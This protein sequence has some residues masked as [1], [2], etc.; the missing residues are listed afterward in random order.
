MTMTSLKLDASESKNE[1]AAISP[2]YDKPAYPYG[3]SIDLDETA[4]TKLG[5]TDLPQV[6]DELGATMVLK[7]KSVSA[8]D[9]ESTEGSRRSLC[10]QITDM[11]LQSGEGQSA[12]DRLYSKTQPAQGD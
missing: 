8:Y 9:S 5:V 6:G 1:G 7:V 10:L 3:T 12:A 4:L 11:E 2:D